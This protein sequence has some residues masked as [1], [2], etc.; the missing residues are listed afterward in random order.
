MIFF[1][2][3]K[4][5]EIKI[6]AVC[7]LAS[8]LFWLL[9]AMN[10]SYNIDVTHPLKIEYDEDEYV[11]MSELP[12][13]VRFNTTASGWDLIKNTSYL[14]SDPIVLNLGD[15]KKKRY[16]TASKLYPIVSKQMKGIK[17]NYIIDDTIFIDVN[18]LKEKK[19]SLYL[20]KDS[21]ILSDDQLIDGPIVIEPSTVWVS[22]PESMI[23]KVP[24]K[25]PLKLKIENP[26]SEYDETW[27]IETNLNPK[28]EV[29]QEK[30]RIR[31]KTRVKNEM[32]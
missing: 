11:V 17:V 21:V 18:P 26:H 16:I 19:V 4:K 7:V 1:W 22:G 20:P 10:E 30:V 29:K 5:D 12:R 28:I 2:R 13:S 25:V 24:A 9:M 8:T 6:L 23:N 15:F 14:S 31:F 32:K 27:S 3:I